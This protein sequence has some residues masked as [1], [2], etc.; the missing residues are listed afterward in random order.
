VQLSDMEDKVRNAN[1]ATAT[2]KSQLDA[3]KLEVADT[4]ALFAGDAAAGGGGGGASSA[5]LDA[6]REALDQAQE[7]LAIA[8]D[9]N[10]SLSNEMRL[11]EQKISVY[12]QLVSQRSSGPT[13]METV[14][15]PS[16]NPAQSRSADP[17]DVDTCA[18]V[19]FA[20]KQSC[21]KVPLLLQIMEISVY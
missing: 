7:E 21:A 8:N 18:A 10:E 16:G 6:A 14:S 3:A 4:I 13:G 2:M 15:V 20:V 17:A 1:S 12:E 9:R 5:D 11:L 19:I